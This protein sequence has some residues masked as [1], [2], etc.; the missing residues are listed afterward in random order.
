M[1]KILLDCLRTVEVLEGQ[2]VGCMQAFCMRWNCPNGIHYRT[3]D[4]ALSAETIDI[5]ETSQGGSVPL[6]KLLNRGDEPVFL[7][8]GEQL[9]GAKQNRILNVSILTA[10]RGKLTIPVSCVEAGRWHYHSPK[11][12]SPGTLSH[13]KLRKLVS[14]HVYES[15]TRGAGAVSKQGEVWDEV[16]RKLH[17]LGSF[18]LSAALQQ[19]YDDFQ[20]RLDRLVDDLHVPSECAGCVV[21]IAG[22]IAGMDIFD[23]PATLAKL[24]RKLVWA[25][26]LDAFEEKAE[27]T[28]LVTCDAVREWLHSLGEVPS[29]FSKSPG[30]GHHVHLRNEKIIGSCLVVEQCPIHAEFFDLDSSAV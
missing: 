9:M 23:Q 21:A 17:C 18:S 4:E 26:A 14:G 25:Y 12:T 7:M 16:G 8:A 19:T 1:N 27:A 15:A 6:L 30:L 11:F 20:T 22:R 29:H 5:T 13:S 3:L 10:A 2:T 24:W 28:Q